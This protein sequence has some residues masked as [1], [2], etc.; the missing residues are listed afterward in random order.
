MRHRYHLLY[1]LAGLSVNGMCGS[2]LIVAPRRFIFSKHNEKYMYTYY[3]FSHFSLGIL[4]GAEFISLVDCHVK[5]T[6]VSCFM[7]HLGRSSYIYSHRIYTMHCPLRAMSAGADISEQLCSHIKKFV[8]TALQ[9]WSG[10]DHTR[11]AVPNLLLDHIKAIVRAEMPPASSPRELN[12]QCSTYAALLIRY[13]NHGCG[14]LD[15]LCRTKEDVKIIIENEIYRNITNEKIFYDITSHHH[16]IQDKSWDSTVANADD[17][18]TYAQAA[19]QMGEKKWVRIANDW[20]RSSC[21]KFFFH[22]G[23]KK[24]YIKSLKKANGGQV[25]K[26]ALK[27]LTLS[28]NLMDNNETSLGSAFDSKIRMLDVG[29]CYNPLAASE[30]AGF[31]IDAGVPQ[32]SI[33]LLGIDLYPA[34]PTVLQCDFLN[35]DISPPAT[36]V[37]TGP[38]LD[39]LEAGDYCRV[40]S[41]PAESFDAACM[42]LVLSYLP[43]PAQRL[44]MVQ[45]AWALLKCPSAEDG[46]E[47]HR[48][49]MLVIVEKIS[50][51]G[52]NPSSRKFLNDWRDEIERVGFDMVSAQVLSGTSNHA[53]GM[54]FRK[55]SRSAIVS[56]TMGGL[57]TRRERTRCLDGLDI[58]DELPLQEE[59]PAAKKQKV[60]HNSDSIVKVQKARSKLG[61]SAAR[62]IRV[63][64]VGGGI[65]GIALAVALQKIKHVSFTVYEKDASFSCRKQGI[66][67]NIHSFIDFN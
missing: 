42:C 53:Y 63:A 58:N 24:A 38:A 32:D 11:N 25:S 45:N 12:K 33:D 15:K 9:G 62:A 59:E 20:I 51:F 65:G 13:L 56:G 23:A 26:E 39:I 52:N 44:K 5:C 50:V 22:G 46:P 27:S 2:G 66:V 3:F 36:A 41:L 6:A 1:T 4:C 35:V 40:V 34:N 54:I 8:S 21:Y 49:G 7:W 60:N 37:Q 10:D 19:T 17:L 43:D 28:N 61:S 55:V 30:S 57:Y 64:I 31:S 14:D 67:K 16:D 18:A 29:A 48:T 47:P